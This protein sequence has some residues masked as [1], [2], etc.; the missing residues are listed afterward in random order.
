VKRFLGWLV[1]EADR[2]LHHSTLGLRVIRGTCLVDEA[3][4]GGSLMFNRPVFLEFR[5]EGLW[6]GGLVL[7]FMVWGV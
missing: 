6:F 4:L 2:L 7:G 3:F 5:V 1:F